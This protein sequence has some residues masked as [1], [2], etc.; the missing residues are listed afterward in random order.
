M[1]KRFDSAGKWKRVGLFLAAAALCGAA[2]A[3]VQGS[4]SFA[5]EPT[6]APQ[7]RADAVAG[8]VLAPPAFS[9]PVEPLG[10]SAPG[11]IYLGQQYSLASLDFLDENH[12]LFTFR[13][14]GLIHRE[15]GTGG[16]DETDEHHVR[17]LVLEVTSGAVQAEAVWS[18]RDRAPY[19]WVLRDG[20]FLLRDGDTLKQGDAML[21]LKPIL[22]FPG[23][24][25]SVEVD[26]TQK[27]LVTN[28]RE[29][30]A[31][32]AKPGEVA[33][34]ATATANVTVDGKKPTGQTDVVL[35]ILHRDTGQ[36]MLVAH[37][38]SIVRLP[39]NDDGYLESQRVTDTK[40]LVNL[41][42]FTGGS[43]AVGRVETTCSPALEFIAQ[44]EV[45]ASTCNAE[46]DR[47]VVAMDGEGLHLWEET[48][49][50][51]QVWP[52]TVLAA[53]GLRLARESLVIAHP[54]DASHPFSREDVKGQVVEVIDAANGQRALTAQASPAL[55]AGGNVGLSPS[56]R[57]VAVLNGGTIQV[58]E[59]PAAP[60]LP[61]AAANQ[62]GR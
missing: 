8:K 35:R 40:W 60:P 28:S 17:A 38:G 30:V 48:A 47:T 22:H 15:H 59:L 53:T 5:P 54:V 34:P 32:A 23:P 1:T 41:N 52:R 51:T 39:I 14:P 57:R 16:D 19:L 2:A 50:A 33:S 6:R 62:P 46:G 13:V 12:L 44:R 25:L 20:H 4:G 31:A 10:F 24:L 61:Q 58:F 55:D 45:L 18:L 3:Q 42:H 56:G 29:P 36:V 49:P 7:A 26:P 27:F 43:T 11:P 9:I 37:V 21:T